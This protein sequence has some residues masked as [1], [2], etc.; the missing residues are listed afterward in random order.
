[1]DTRIATYNSNN[2]QKISYVLS[3][4]TGQFYNLDIDDLCSDIDYLNHKKLDWEDG[5]TLCNLFKSSLNHLKN[6]NTM[7]KSKLNILLPKVFNI[8]NI[9]STVI[10]QAKKI[11]SILNHKGMIW[12][13][14]PSENPSQP[15]IN[16]IHK[17]QNIFHQQKNRELH[18]ISLENFDQ[19]IIQNINK[20]NY[21]ET[22]LN[23]DENV[24]SFDI[25][26]RFAATFSKNKIKL[27]DLETEKCLWEKSSILLPK[28]IKITEGLVFCTCA[29]NYSSSQQP[30]FI[31]IIDLQ[32]GIHKCSITAW[33]IKNDSYYY[34]AKDKKIYRIFYDGNIR[35]YNL[36]GKLVRE[37]DSKIEKMTLV[38]ADVP[39]FLLG[40][41]NFLIHIAA[42]TIII[43]DLMKEN[44]N[45]KIE[46]QKKR[47]LSDGLNGVILSAHIQ[48]DR[49]ICGINT[50]SGNPH[51][52]VIG[53][54]EIDLISGD[55]IHQYRFNVPNFL[56]VAI[57]VTIKKM[58][59]H[60]EWAYL[61]L[62]NGMIVAV[63][64]AEKTHFILGKN[65]PINFLSIENDTLI[66]GSNGTFGDPAQLK[67]WDIKS[68]T[69]IAKIKIPDVSVVSYVSG[70]VYAA[71]ENS[72]I[73]RK[74]LV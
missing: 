31:E 27:W 67:F 45:K 16:T 48:G 11:D 10:E 44:H 54:C 34:Y 46:F 59:M 73:I 9:N 17:S 25:Q 23:H 63:N 39:E 68:L 15:P 22:I 42:K 51:C 56:D 18:G 33:N 28:E 24:K 57:D 43:H 30:K 72:L 69:E 14:D 2:F 38:D 41:K 36:K 13:L 50:D 52:C 58:I 61:G 20:T 47:T 26:D 19:R 62:S 49:L 3:N 29:A 53:F 70:N 5:I 8:K 74:Y 64:L 1:M 7:L 55:I 65:Y 32:T 6:E 4:K 66:S 21:T 37:I 60:K 71:T 35:E 12:H 40:S